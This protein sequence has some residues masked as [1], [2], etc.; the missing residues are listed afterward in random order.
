MSKRGTRTK[1][2]DV[3]ALVAAC[4][5]IERSTSTQMIYATMRFMWD[6]YL[7]HPPTGAWWARFYAKHPR[8]P[9]PR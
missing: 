8:A 6:R 9:R 4:K 7:I 3:L 5:A 2:P 1:D